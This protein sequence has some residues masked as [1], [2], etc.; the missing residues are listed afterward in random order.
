MV[1]DIYHSTAIKGQPE[2]RIG[3]YH[4][5]AIQGQP[6]IRIGMNIATRAGTSDIDVVRGSQHRGQGRDK[7]SSQGPVRVKDFCYGY[8]Q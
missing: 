3:I 7:R 5:T 4:S 8:S 1:I 2:I 6:E